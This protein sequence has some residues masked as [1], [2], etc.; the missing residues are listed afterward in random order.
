[1]G[2]AVALVATLDTKGAELTYL[3]SVLAKMGVGSVVID[4][5]VFPPEGLIPDVPREK[6]AELGGQGLDELKNKRRDEIMRVMGDGLRKCLLDLY[7]KEEIGGALAVGG[8][9]GTAVASM[10]FRGLPFG[11]PKV[12]V[13]TVASGNVRPYIGHKDITMMFSVADFLGGVNAVIRPVLDNAAAAVG[14][15]MREKPVVGPE[16]QKKGRIATTAF[17]NTHGAVVRAKALLEEA[18]YEVIPFHASGACG[19]AMEELIAAGYFTGVLDLT[20]HELV[21]EVLGHDI[22]TPVLPGR[23]ETA[24]REGIPQVVAPGGLNY[25]CFGP[26]ESVPGFLRK[27][28]THYHNP[29]NTNVRTTREELNKLGEV[30]AGRLNASR[31]PVAVVIPLQGWSENGREGKPLYDPDADRALVEALRRYLRKEIPLI[32]VDAHI[33]DP[34]F[35]EVAV[36]QLLSMMEK[37]KS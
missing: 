11:F 3:R 15:M 13:S 34:G 1:M 27:R 19:S 26:V 9:Q 24:G 22:Y 16:D 28:A 18:G 36:E 31:G 21:G 6:I 12:I 10:G 33:N 14:G 20:T 4:I 2:K 29:Y 32:E 17:G 35:V 30:M 25:Y 5:G 37:K 23:L 7:R 8:N